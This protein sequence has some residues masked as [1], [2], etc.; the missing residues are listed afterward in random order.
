MFL[1]SR[2]AEE[3]R[4]GRGKKDAV[5]RSVTWAGESIATSGATVVIAFG[6]LAF[7]SFGLLRSVGIAVMLGISIALLVALTLV[8]AALSL[9]G[10]RIFW[11]R[12]LGLWRK[13]KLVGGS[14]YARAA[15]FTAKHSK[16]VL[17]LALAI[18]LPAARIALSSQT[19]HDLIG[20]IPS[21]LESK[22]R[23]NTMSQGFCAGTVTPTYTLV[24]T[25]CILSSARCVI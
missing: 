13:K 15:Q 10:D 17:L 7:A 16:L 19:S 21:S 23:Y 3:R 8:P 4:L 20:Q 5:E 6:T 18:S 22:N 1:G 12:G 24:K 11:P 2:Y 25:P 9:F 14:Y